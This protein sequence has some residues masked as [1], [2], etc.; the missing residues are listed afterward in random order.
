MRSC[1]INMRR[2]CMRKGSFTEPR[3]R[4]ACSSEM[5]C[6]SPLRI[7]KVCSVDKKWRCF[8]YVMTFGSL[9]CQFSLVIKKKTAT[10]DLCLMSLLM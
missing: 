7:I 8:S 3:S 9:L 10:A 5:L 2:L 1:V 4:A 6:F